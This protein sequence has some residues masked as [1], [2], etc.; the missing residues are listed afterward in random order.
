MDL[1]PNGL[2]FILDHEGF[3]AMRCHMTTRRVTVPSGT[4]HPKLPNQG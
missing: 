4:R 1:S 2:V 3:S